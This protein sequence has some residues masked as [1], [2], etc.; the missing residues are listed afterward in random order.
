MWHCVTKNKMKRTLW[1]R[2][3]M[4]YQKIEFDFEI[5]SLQL[6]MRMFEFIAGGVH[7][8][9]FS[10]WSRPWIA[11]L[12]LFSKPNLVQ[13]I[14]NANLVRVYSVSMS[15]I[16]VQ[17]SVNNSGD[18]SAGKL[19]GSVWFC[20]SLQNLSPSSIIRLKSNTNSPTREY[21]RSEFRRFSIS[22]NAMI[23]N[24]N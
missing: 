8:W 11:L 10:N 9:A 7:G 16:L 17:R 4:N 3:K 14:S 15:C 20:I 18:K 19:L 22:A 6:L 24:E 5:N 23:K 21:F 13:S 2:R 12:L 1:Q